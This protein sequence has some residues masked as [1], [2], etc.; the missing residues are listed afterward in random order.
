M[1]MLEKAG[2]H[3]AKKILARPHNH[4]GSPIPPPYLPDFPFSHRYLPN[5]TQIIVFS[6]TSLATLLVHLSFYTLNIWLFLLLPT[7]TFGNPGFL[8]APPPHFFNVLP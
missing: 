3:L 1:S 6:G 2:K 5:L 7:L 4:V 8:T